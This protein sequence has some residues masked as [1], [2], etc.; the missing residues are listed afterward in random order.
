MPEFQKY[1]EEFPQARPESASIV[2]DFLYWSK[3]D[4][5]LKPVTSVTHVT[6]YKRSHGHCFGRDHRFERNLWQP[7][8]QIVSRTDGIYTSSGSDPPRTYLIYV[9]RS[10]TDA[11]RGLFPG[12]K[13]SLLA[14]VS[15]TARRRTWKRSGRDC[16]WITEN[17]IQSTEI[18]REHE[19]S[20]IPSHYENME[21]QQMIETIEACELCSE[22]E[23][24]QVESSLS[25]G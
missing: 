7:L 20:D 13:R 17:G 12:L 15:A 3:E 25:G 18:Q 5:G 23:W 1:L 10:R 8:L 16:R 6:I 14:A 22:S 4:F 24:A 19:T 11:L 21:V 9:N 2:E